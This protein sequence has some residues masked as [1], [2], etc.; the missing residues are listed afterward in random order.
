MMKQYIGIFICCNKTYKC[1]HRRQKHHI[2]LMVEVVKSESNI[3]FL[4]VVC[5]YYK[6]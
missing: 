6:N 3:F 2:L 4:S 5:I 1:I